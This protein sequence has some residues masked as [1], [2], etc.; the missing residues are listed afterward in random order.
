MLHKSDIDRLRQLAAFL[1]PLAD[2]P[3]TLEQAANVEQTVRE[4]I[5]RRSHIMAEID[6]AT[7]QRHEADR[8]L[9]DRE[10]RI[11]ERE[12]HAKEV[13]AAIEEKA[14]TDAQALVDSAQEKA[15][16]IRADA[17]SYA[18]RIQHDAAVIDKSIAAKR[19]EAATLE[20]RVADAKAYLKKLKDE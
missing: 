9:D 4:A 14:I 20:K 17:D 18:E 2:L 3:E 1:K 5:A 19:A 12:K 15:A 16:D 7:T 11:A 8:A 13:A 6:A 10:K